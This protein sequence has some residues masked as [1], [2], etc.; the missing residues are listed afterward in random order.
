[1]GNNCKEKNGRYLGDFCIT[2]TYFVIEDGS[3]VHGKKDI[4]ENKGL[5]NKARVKCFIYSI[6]WPP[7]SP[8][9]NPIE[10]V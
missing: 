5:Y 6:N 10:N 3:K 8:N 9:L 4:K 2:K 7:Y 1:L